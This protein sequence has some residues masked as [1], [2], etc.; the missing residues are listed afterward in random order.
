MRL[1]SVFLIAFGVAS[2]QPTYTA[3]SLQT[4]TN[5]I[6]NILGLNNKGQV[7]G[8]TCDFVGSYLYC[9][10]S[11]RYPAVWS[12][13]AIT[14]LPIPEG[15][16]YV[17]VPVY[18]GINDSGIVVGTLE[19]P[20]PNNVAYNHVFV[21]ANGIPTMLPDAPVP[22]ACSGAG[23][24]CSTSGS[25]TS[26][27]INA[28]GHIVGLTSYLSGVPGGASCSAYWVYDG[29]N[30]HLLPYPQPAQCPASTTNI[31]LPPTFNDA[32][33]VLETVQSVFCGPPFHDVS[34]PFPG[35]DP[36]VVQPS[37]SFAFLPVGTLAA[38][39]GASINDVGDVLGSW[40]NGGGTTDLLV[41]DTKGLHDFGPSGYGHMNQVGQVVYLT[42]PCAGC[43]AGIAM[44]QNGV[45]TAVQLPSG[46]SG[47]SGPSALND[48][49][50]FTT[51]GYL[52]TPTGPCAQDITSQVQVTRGGYLY[53]RST[54]RFVQTITLTNT[55]GS[56]ISGPISLALDSLPSNASLYAISG[57]TLCDTPQGSPYITIGA[58]SLD[59][60]VPVAS[61]VQFI[62]TA[63]TGIS[64]SLRVLAGAGGR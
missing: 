48:A 36:A 31:Y 15:Y 14:P 21:W 5:G 50:Q 60:G 19:I 20:G 23:C 56:S 37:G 55:G 42:S 39:S 63:K 64:Y 27:G 43:G 28:A 25:S 33:Q 59:P 44:W 40:S 38:A 58:A 12:N 18:Y 29:A 61:T 35:A 30:F 4:S 32:D 11:H 8:D 22:G 1:L 51:D 49:G 24:P 26:F 3:T 52:L 7:L 53:N 45:S 46:V 47:Q 41:W 13:G 54:G 17:A 16:S 57:T 9:Y 10:G 2:A 62:D 6:A 34:P